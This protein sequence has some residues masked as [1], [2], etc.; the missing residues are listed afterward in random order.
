MNFEG[1]LLVVGAFSFYSKI[2]LFPPLLVTDHL[3]RSWWWPTCGATAAP[4]AP[5]LT[6]PA[7]GGTPGGGRWTVPWIG[8]ASRSQDR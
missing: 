7:G 1:S 2:V 6:T 4:P 3:T 5:S 8:T